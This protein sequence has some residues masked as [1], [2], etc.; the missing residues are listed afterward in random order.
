[1]V[2][3]LLE[4]LMAPITSEFGFLECD[5]KIAANEFYQWHSQLAKEKN[6]YYE[7]QDIVAP[8]LEVLLQKLL[9]LT[10]TGHHKYMFIPTYGNKWTACFDD[11]WRGADPTSY[12]SYLAEKIGCRGVRVS[13]VPNTI[14]RDLNAKHGWRGN[15]GSVIFDV[16]GPKPNPILNYLRTVELVNDGG[17]W[18][19]IANGKPFDFEQTERYKL[20]RKTD[21]FTPEMLENYLKNLEIDAF[22]ED[23]Y[24][25]TRENPA[26]LVSL[27]GDIGYEVK[28]CSLEQAREDY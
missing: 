7:M 20:P 1:M 13:W 17:K 16:F 26:K 3:L 18:E 12:V 19:F 15:Y 6:Y 11:G 27:K 10:V 28:E 23:F 4:D 8:S 21:R 2:K 22:S 24:I 25:A 9:P 5:A 14:R